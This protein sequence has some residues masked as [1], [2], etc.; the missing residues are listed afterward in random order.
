M[1]L[2]NLQI[3]RTKRGLSYQDMATRLGIT[4][5]AYWMIENGKR[6][7]SY[8]MAVK[9]AKILDKTPDEIFLI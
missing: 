7:L 6:G 9:I 2:Q 4:L 8:E 3:I 1:N 5:Q